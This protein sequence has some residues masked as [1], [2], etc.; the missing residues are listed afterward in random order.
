[1]PSDFFDVIQFRFY[2]DSVEELLSYYDE[3]DEPYDYVKFTPILFNRWTDWAR[4][5]KVKDQDALR[6]F[7][8]RLGPDWMKSEFSGLEDFYQYYLAL[9]EE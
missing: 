8:E 5:Y 9:L 1:M 3:V 6:P 4:K 2:L 7:G